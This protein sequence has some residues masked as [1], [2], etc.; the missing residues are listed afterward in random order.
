MK[1]KKYHTD[2]TV[3]KFILKSGEIDTP[4]TQ[5]HDRLSSWLSTVISVNGGRVKLVLRAQY[6][7]QVSKNAY[8]EHDRSEIKNNK[9]I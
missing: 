1:H 7:Q 4:K 9:L 3:R 2:G 5:I 6:N 8:F